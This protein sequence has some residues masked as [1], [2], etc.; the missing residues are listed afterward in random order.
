M[1]FSLSLSLA[2]TQ[3]SAHAIVAF[4][5]QCDPHNC[6][7]FQLAGRSFYQPTLAVCDLLRAQL[8]VRVASVYDGPRQFALFRLS[9]TARAIARA[10]GTRQP[11]KLPC[12]RDAPLCRLEGRGVSPFP[13][14][15]EALRRRQMDMR[16][17]T[18]A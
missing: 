13:V 7:S 5:D 8:L 15:V 11:P 3:A 16:A 1:R 6:A 12:L 17:S 9:T 18:C 10:T 2:P 14:P 4:D